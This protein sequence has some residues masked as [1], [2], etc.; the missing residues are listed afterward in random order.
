MCFK[1]YVNYIAVDYISLLVFHVTLNGH[2]K[3]L[4]GSL[5]ITRYSDCAVC[6]HHDNVLCF[7]KA[8]AFWGG[9]NKP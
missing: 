3:K 4:W 1:C 9:I 8:L 6:K 2:N 7:V 5:G